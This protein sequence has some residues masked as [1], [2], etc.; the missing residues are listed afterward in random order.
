[1]TIDYLKYETVID[2]KLITLKP[3]HLDSHPAISFCLK[4]SSF[5]SG[6]NETSPIIDSIGEISCRMFTGM[7]DVSSNIVNFVFFF[8]LTNLKT[9]QNQ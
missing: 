1:L 2:L 7:T 3:K 9:W 4:P 6:I 8:E 5:Y